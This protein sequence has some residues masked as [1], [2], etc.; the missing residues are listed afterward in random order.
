[1]YLA[2]LYL[3][4]AASEAEAILASDGRKT[5]VM[6][7]NAERWSPRAFSRQWSR[8]LITNNDMA[9]LQQF[10]REVIQFNDLLGGNLQ[11]GDQLVIAR[12]GSGATV[13]SVNGQQVMT[14]EKPGFFE[15]VLAAWI[16]DRPP[17]TEF[18]A[19]LLAANSN[20]SLRVALESLQPVAGSERALPFWLAKNS[21][22]ASAEQTLAV[23]ASEQ[24]AAAVAAVEAS[25]VKRDAAASQTQAKQ[26]QANVTA[27]PKQLAP[28]KPAPAIAAAPDATAPAMEAPVVAAPVLAAASPAPAAEPEPEE[29]ALDAEQQAALR[30]L[31]KTMVARGVLSNIQ[32]PSKALKKGWQGKVLLNVSVGRTG[33][34]EGLNILEEA[35]FSSLNDAAVEA[36]EKVGQFPPLP[37]AL[38]GEYVVVQVP[39]NFRL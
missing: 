33:A 37:A 11:R 9:Q 12:D 29:V 4:Q 20:D 27:E 13:A 39:V 1:V 21:A 7:V 8:A 19:A 5:M 28:T 18:K 30:A 34:I 2:Q 22:P 26:A 17:S 3:E 24:V 32:Y 16:G 31:Y 10:D 14:I 38:E 25:P 36:V 15:L 35:R 6:T 23:A